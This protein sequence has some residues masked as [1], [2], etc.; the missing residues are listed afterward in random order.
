MIINYK[1]G[2][3]YKG[4]K[5]AWKDKE[6]HRLPNN[7]GLKHFPLKKLK[8]IKVGNKEGY[9]VAQDKKTIEQLMELTEVIDYKY[10]INGAGDDN[11][12]F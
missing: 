9:R 8:K 7:I 12:P 3:E 2:F 4:I 11:C 5:Y 6:L 1:Y 10:I